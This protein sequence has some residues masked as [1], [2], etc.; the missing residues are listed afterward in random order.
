[1]A[2]RLVDALAVLTGQS[3]ADLHME[4]QSSA[5]VLPLV[6]VGMHATIIDQRPDLYAAKSRLEAASTSAQ[7]A[8][9]SRSRYEHGY[10]SYFEVVDAD[11]DALNIERQLIRSRQ[12][13]AAATI[14]LVRALRG[15]W[16]GADL[17][18]AASQLA[19]SR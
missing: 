11:R 19:Q 3:V 14:A 2:T 15:G 7:A 10:V 4:A 8:R 18:P 1:V 6:P 13:Q 9:L 16:N 12:A 17:T 5:L